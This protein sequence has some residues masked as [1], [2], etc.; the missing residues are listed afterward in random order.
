MSLR[1]SHASAVLLQRQRDWQGK[2]ITL[3]SLRS[4]REKYKW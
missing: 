2:Y 1:P 4:L 3:R